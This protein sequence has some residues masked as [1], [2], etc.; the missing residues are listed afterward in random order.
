MSKMQS[1]QFQDVFPSVV[2]HR[3]TG[4]NLASLADGAGSSTTITVNGVALGD[5]VLGVAF[6]VDLSGMTVTAYVS[7]ANTVTVRAQNESA[8]AVDLAST[9]VTLVVAKVKQT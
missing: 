2:V 1:R 7:A 9:T 3:E 6:G 5:V 4:V 8:G